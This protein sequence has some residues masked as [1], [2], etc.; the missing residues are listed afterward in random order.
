MFQSRSISQPAQGIGQD[1]LRLQH[2]GNKVV[3]GIADGAGGCSGGAE[4][5]DLA[6]DL[7]FR[8][9]DSLTSQE[10]CVKKLAQIDHMISS[11]PHA[12]ETTAVLVVVGPTGVFGASVGDSGAL[13]LG[14]GGIDDLTRNQT[15]KPFLGTGA[16]VPVGF[17]RGA[18]AG[19]LIMA[20][21]GLFKYTS[22]EFIRAAVEKSGFDDAPVALVNLVR[23][24]SGNLPDD[25]AICLCRPT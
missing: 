8:Q 7:L 4:A 6:I 20:T 1:R 17:T 24:A 13:I 2:V 10:Q 22:P 18:L 15:G 9:T 19:T 21:D 16:A 3:F 12:G 11:D 23:Y 14:D 25:V 5:A